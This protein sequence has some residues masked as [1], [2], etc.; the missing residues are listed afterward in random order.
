MEGKRLRYYTIGLKSLE[1]SIHD[2]YV[3]TFDTISSTNTGMYT[4]VV[5]LIG[6]RFRNQD[7][8]RYVAAP[9]S[10]VNNKARA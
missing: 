3:E 5:L 10:R 2:M 9:T 1:N 8:P 6:W 7:T 4:V